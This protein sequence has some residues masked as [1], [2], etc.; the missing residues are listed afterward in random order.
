MVIQSFHLLTII[1]FKNCKIEMYPVSW[2]YFSLMH[3]INELNIFQLQFQ[4]QIEHAMETIYF[5]HAATTPVDEQVLDAMLPFFKTEYGN[6]D[7]IHQLGQ[8]AKVALEDARESVARMINAEPSEIIF[9]CGGTESNN[10]VIKG[11]FEVSGN[12]KEIISS[13]IE[14]HAVFH[15]IECTK[16]QGGKPVYLAPDQNGIITPEQVKNAINEKT[17]LVSLM[18]VN[19]ELGTI[20]PIKEIAEVCRENGVLFHSDTVQSAGKIPVDVKDLGID[21][22]SISGHKIYGPKG[23]GVMYVKNGSPWVPWMTG[24]SQERRRRGGTSNIPGIV[25]LAKALEITTARMEDYRS[26]FIKLRKHLLHKMDQVFGNRY[27]INGPA[28]GGVPHIINLG[29]KH[30]G[31]SKLDGEMLL[32]NLDIEGI[33]VSNGSACTSGAVEPSHVLTGIGLDEDIADSS[34]RVSFGKDNTIQEVDRFVEVLQGVL[35]R[36]MVVARS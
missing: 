11:V 19:N 21:F 10:A 7:S 3:L 4:I 2:Y 35:D 26:H 20:N 34:I 15:T 23:T 6:A 18:H 36:M 31:E 28:H 5:D 8:R 17:A 12:K 13:R 22:L 16:R 32:L 1:I 14:H 30:T 24:G 33:C 25:G 27:Q 9:T 29:I